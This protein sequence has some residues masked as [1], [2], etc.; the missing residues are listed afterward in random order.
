MSTV[1]IAPADRAADLAAVRALFRAYAN[2]L[3]FDLGFQGFE[4][5]LAGLP[6]KYAPPAGA[7]LLAWLGD[8]AVGCVAMRDLGDGV[9][10]MKR[11]YLDPRARGHGIGRALIAGLIAVAR[12]AGYRAM[13]LDTL[14]GEHDQAIALYRLFGFVEIEAYCFNPMPGIKYFELDL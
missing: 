7:I 10:E 2:S 3:S 9:C 4:D 11:L 12:A 8:A 1:R 14:P 5:E 6:G 13:R